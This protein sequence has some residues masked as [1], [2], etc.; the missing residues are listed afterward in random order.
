L[1]FTLF[2]PNISVY[3]ASVRLLKWPESVQLQLWEWGAL[4]DHLVA[5]PFLAIPGAGGSPHIDPQPQPINWTSPDP[6]PHH[7]LAAAAE[8]TGLQGVAS[9]QEKLSAAPVF[10]SGTVFVRSGWVP[11]GGLAVVRPG[12]FGGALAK[13]GAEEVDAADGLAPDQFDAA[14]GLAMLTVVQPFDAAVRPRD[15]GGGHDTARV[16]S[17]GTLGAWVTYENPLSAYGDGG[18]VRDTAGG[19]GWGGSAATFKG[20]GGYQ[21]T[22]TSLHSNPLAVGAWG[23]PGWDVEAA[24]AL[25]PPQPALSAEAALRRAVVGGCMVR[26]DTLMPPSAEVARQQGTP[27]MPATFTSED[28]GLSQG[29]MWRLMPFVAATASSAFLC[30]PGFP[31]ACCEVAG[32]AAAGPQRPP[33][34]AAARAAEGAR[35][36]WRQGRG[37]AGGAHAPAHA[38]R[39]CCTKCISGGY[40]A[41]C[42]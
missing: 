8:A 26:S 15:S 29:R 19:R 31:P 14:D 27:T 23:S 39:I 9:Q 20:T 1:C 16:G 25:V 41:L 13:G 33:Q 3:R 28:S 18:G 10:P 11:K 6:I 34:R 30:K 5:A 36:C 2:Q 7:E 32:A 22:V 42:C 17:A 4:H 35:G 40:T 21:Q 38:L 12:A 37:A 24:P